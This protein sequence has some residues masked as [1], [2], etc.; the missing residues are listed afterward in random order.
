MLKIALMDGGSVNMGDLSWDGLQVYGQ[1]VEY[2]VVPPNADPVP[3]IGDCDVVVGSKLNI[4]AE[5]MDACPNLKFINVPA[6]GFQCVDIAAARERG[7]AV[8]NVPRYSTDAVAQHIFALLLNHSNK[9]MVHHRAVQKGEWCH[10]PAFCYVKEPLMELTGKTFCVLGFGAIGKKTLQIARAF[11]MKTIAIPHR[12]GETVSTEGVE[13]VS[14]EEGFRRAD[15]LALTCPLTAE[16]KEIV[17]AK[18]LALMKPTA[19]LINTARG[20]L[21][22]EADLIDALNGDRLAG[23]GAD[24]VYYEPMVETCQLPYAKNVVLTSHVA[25]SPRETRARMIEI[26]LQNMEAWVKGERLNRVD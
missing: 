19:L 20:R 24:C 2:S 26:V 22:N 23:Y 8:A 15:V 13:F 18:T 5:V 6:T 10:A 17:N 4:T 14:R 1:V 3:M 11:G 16:T 12:E 25:W 7:I 21:V 9:I